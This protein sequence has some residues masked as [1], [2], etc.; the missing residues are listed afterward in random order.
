MDEEDVVRVDG[1]FVPLHQ[2]LDF[3]EGNDDA[4]PNTGVDITL[5]PPTNATADMTDEDSGEED[6]VE[7][8]NVPPKPS[9]CSC[10]A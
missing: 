9:E 6:N 4:I 7:I 10:F 8:D 2:L 5:L 3:I 1:R